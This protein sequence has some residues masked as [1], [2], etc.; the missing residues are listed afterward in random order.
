MTAPKVS[1]NLCCY[2]SERFLE[3][4][5]ASIFSQ[6]CADYELV[7]VNDGSSDRTDEIVRGHIARGREIVYQPQPNAGLGAARNKALELSKGELIAII[8]HDDVWEPE[9]LARQLPL[10]R[11]PEVGFAGC[12]ALYVDSA[13]RPLGRYSLQAPL[14]RGR[15]LRELFLW[16]FIPCAAVVMRRSAIEKAGGFFKPDYRIAEEYELFLRLAGVSSFDFDPEPLVRLRVHPGSAGWDCARERAEMRRAYGECLRREPALA[17]G[18]GADELAIKRAGLWLRPGTSPLKR[19]ALR[20]V[21]ALGPAAVDALAGA[22]RFLA[23]L[24]A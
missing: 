3:E 5:L 1:V 2:N 22:K 10:F 19:A 4:T 11:D 21:A 12:D 7:I 18:L 17:A 13:G 6:T 24:A 8:D 16:N 20:G 15:V 9:K 14:R 23:R